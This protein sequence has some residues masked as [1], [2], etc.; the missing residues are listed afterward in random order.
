MKNLRMALAQNP[1]LT[2]TEQRRCDLGRD[3]VL[4]LLL[5]AAGPGAGA[6]A[7]TKL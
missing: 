7:A 3:E 5:P 2:G 1:L 6:L 4:H